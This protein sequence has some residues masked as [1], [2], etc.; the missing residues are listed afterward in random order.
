MRCAGSTALRREWMPMPQHRLS[1]LIGGMQ[2]R[3]RS[4]RLYHPEA[5]AWP[6]QS[7]PPLPYHASS[8][9]RK[10]RLAGRQNGLP[11]LGCLRLRHRF[12]RFQKRREHQ[13]KPS[14]HASARH[15]GRGS[16]R[17]HANWNVLPCRGGRK[18]A[19]PRRK[20]PV[21]RRCR[22]SSSRILQ[23]CGA[24]CRGL[25][26]IRHRCASRSRPVQACIRR[27]TC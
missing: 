18:G 20:N 17:R 13:A 6:M 2:A 12:S 3:M 15:S 10:T 25:R 5:H 21:G 9:H 16:R 23:G 1:T 24:S 22:P 8:R 19:Y 14:R 4:G 26:A 27:T 7:L 11:V